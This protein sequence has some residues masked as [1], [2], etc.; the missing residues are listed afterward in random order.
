MEGGGRQLCMARSLWM[1]SISFG[2]VNIPVKVV[3]AVRDKDIRFH[4]LHGKDGARIRLKRVCPDEGVE[5]ENDEIVKGYE[6]AKGQYV[7]FTPEEL[8]AADPKAA[9]TIDIEEFVSLDDIDPSYFEKP[10]YLVPDR[11]ATKPYALLHAALKRSAKVGLAKVVMRE[12][13]YLVG[14]RAVEGV[15]MM[16]TMKFADEVVSPASVAQEAGLNDAEPDERQLKLAVQLV[17]SLAADFDPKR[18]HDTHREKLLALVE[19]K[20]AG[21]EVVAEPPS[22]AP[23]ETKDILEALEQSIAHARSAASRPERRPARRKEPPQRP[24]KAVPAT[25]AEARVPRSKSK[26]AKAGGSGVPSRSGAAS[27]SAVAASRGSPKATP[28]ARRDGAE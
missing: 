8:E 26:S 2:L 25:H 3:A 21:H 6:V 19:R 1:G 15:L 27:R 24:V 20:A 22:Q 10:Y 9:R 7:T 16:G 23:R 17:E 12:K 11:D 28:K 4:M 14:I 18:H 13:E 5:V